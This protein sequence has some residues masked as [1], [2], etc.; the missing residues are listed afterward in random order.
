MNINE[1]QV[2]TLKIL[3]LQFQKTRYSHN[4]LYDEASHIEAKKKTSLHPEVKKERK[5]IRRCI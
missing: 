4:Q 5:E 1:P 2:Q 3:R